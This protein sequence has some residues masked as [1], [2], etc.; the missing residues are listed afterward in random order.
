MRC[1]NLR[2]HDGYEGNDLYEHSI[3]V[4]LVYA[5]FSNELA[6]LV[7]PLKAK[8]NRNHKSLQ[9]YVPNDNYD[10]YFFVKLKESGVEPEIAKNLAS[11]KL[12]L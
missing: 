2:F 6:N 8:A 3:F 10:K 7:A 5:G 9:D 11:I 1:K 4:K 12:Q